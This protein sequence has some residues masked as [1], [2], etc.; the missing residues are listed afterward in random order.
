M[1]MLV[2]FVS[3]LGANDSRLIQLAEFL[4]AQCETLALPK[5][6]SGYAEFLDDAL[7]G[8]ACCV[9]VNPAV[10][11]QWTG[12][13]EFPAEI[14]A[15]LL[16]RCSHLLVHG[17]SPRAFDSSLV[18]ALS[19]N[20][21]TGVGDADAKGK[22]YACATDAREFCESFSGLTLGTSRSEREQVF[23]QGRPG[24]RV[25]ISTGGK[26]YAVCTK[27]S[28]ARVWLLGGSGVADLQQQVSENSV[29]SFFSCLLPYAMAIRAIF[30]DRVWRPAAQSASLII[31]DPVLRQTYGFLNFKTL[32]DLAKHNKFH[33]SLAFIP[34]NFRRSSAAVV[35]MFR[36]NPRYLS[37]C[38]HGNDHTRAEFASTDTKLLRALVA[39]AEERM[40]IHDTVSTVQCD[41]VMVFPQGNFSV[42]A[43]A[44]L[45]S[46][47]FDAAVN[48]IAHPMGESNSFTLAELC[49]PA[50]TRYAG[51][52]L[53]L[54]R[55]SALC[56]PPEIAFD[57]FFGRPV[58]LVEH[59]DTFKDTRGLLNAVANINQLCPSINW[60]RLSDAVRHATLRRVANDGTEFIRAYS[61][62]VEVSNSSAVEQE[63]VVQWP[64]LATSDS[65]FCA[66]QGS[67]GA[68]KEFPVSNSEAQVRALVPA[69]ES[70]NFSLRHHQ[71]PTQAARLGLEW[72]TKAFVRRRLSEL[73]DDY[74]SKNASLL[75]FAKTLQRLVAH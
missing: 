44:V 15:C 38:Y 11:R 73:R 8:E 71:Q 72:K 56:Q 66:V 48:T 50:L 26:P 21:L 14:A 42:E 64:K 60:T 55:P 31:D 75:A 18:A 2:P 51:F 25:L 24:A 63:V 37:L 5:L 65:F 53:F 20:Q 28:S 1:K 62:T 35:Q 13:E 47:N 40:Q 7:P 41:R 22:G 6:L 34:H 52:P 4:G 58:F 23:P 27:T 45:Q 43:M 32:L 30:E 3:Q 39:T 33:A 29:T 70:T 36:E 61:S 68:N 9:V 19:E 57:L 12:G 16:A 10:M 67:R 74:L 49:Q 69:Y 17:P 46:R 54:R 59:H